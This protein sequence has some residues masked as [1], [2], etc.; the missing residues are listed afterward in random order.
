M[1][2]DDK[3]M[4]LTN[5]AYVETLLQLVQSVSVLIHDQLG[6]VPPGTNRQEKVSGLVE[7]VTLIVYR[8]CWE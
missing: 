5:V 3:K 8:L 7:L 6:S 1:V 2:A 4:R